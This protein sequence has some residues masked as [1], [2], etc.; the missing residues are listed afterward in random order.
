MWRSPT[1]DRL[2]LGD[3]DAHPSIAV[4]S[5]PFER[6]AGLRIDAKHNA[7]RRTRMYEGLTLV[8]LADGAKST[9]DL[10][11]DVQLSN[12]RWSPDGQRLAL[13]R[14]VKDGV[15]LWVADASTGKSSRV[16]K[17]QLSTVLG[18]GVSWMPGSQSLLVQLV[19]EGHGQPPA[20]PTVPSGPTTMDTTGS[21]ATNRTYQD[22]LK[23]RV[24]EAVF[25]HLATSRIAIVDLAGTVTSLGE[26]DLYSDVSA[27]PDGQYVLS[28]RVKTPFS[29]AVPYY[30]FPRA[31]EV[32]DLKA[33]V[34]RVV[35]DQPV[36]DAVPIGGVREGARGV[37][38]QPTA[39]ATLAWREALDG[40]D[41]D[42]KADHRDR[43]MTHAAPFADTPEERLRTTH[44]LSSVA[45]TERAGE[46]LATEYDRDRRW[47]TT[48]LFGADVVG[49]AGEAD[50]GSK[51]LVDRSSRDAYGDPGRPVYKTLA[52]GHHAL[53]VDE[54]KIYLSGSGATPEGDRPFL[55]RYDLAS[56]A[57]EEL[58]RASG[59]EHV[60]FAGFGSAK[61]DAWMVTRETV[62]VPPDYYLE[63]AG[64]QRR[65]T[66]LPHPHPQLSGIEKRLLKY[67]RKDGVAL[68]GTLYLPP[69]YDADAGEPLPL[70]VWAYP[71]EFNDSDTAGQVRAAP[72]RFTRLRATSA[73]M[74][75]TQGYAVLSPASMPVI[76]DPETM[77]DTFIEQIT[78]A[79]EAAIAACVKEGVADPE[80][81]GVGGHSYGA[82]MT[83]NLLAHSDL[84]SAGLARSGAYNRSLTPFGFQSERRTLWEATETYVAVSPLF[85]ADKLDEPLLLIHGEVDSNAGT[86]PLQSKRLFHALKGV[87]GT[88][89]LVLL[90]AESH[91][92]AS[93]ESVLHV[94]A[95]SFDWFDTYVKNAPPRA[96]AVR[97]ARPG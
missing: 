9:I 79:A 30:R 86:Y 74:F 91:G 40:G 25:K 32:R 90:P 1:Y 71:V 38:W 2:V 84:F 78:D 42:A 96:E 88:A 18:S 47:I 59:K 66:E 75:L 63:G 93:R 73:L 52:S 69:D 8:A 27:S 81:V 39:D 37:H 89:R 21:K 20:R 33:K 7:A 24:D 60:A 62:D 41:P 22:L 72:K 51:V 57:T 26:P 92:Y 80:R 10:P 82:F 48:H 83:A 49:K 5:R 29:Y 67:T 61:H 65:L 16:G 13:S 50:T 3:Y 15:E 43:L 34:V 70:V 85:S 77:N 56:G 55:H 11:D 19:P 53:I 97:A 23:D 44:R 76:G 12:V 54:G 87:G 6:L 94:L 68:S 28:E 46:L 4:V 45:W 64:G 58:M 95:E 36:A 14:W 17:H 35:A 31:I